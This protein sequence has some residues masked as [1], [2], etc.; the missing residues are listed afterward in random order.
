[1]KH[2]ALQRM[3][4]VRKRRVESPLL[5]ASVFDNGLSDRKFAFKMVNGNNQATSCTNL[6]GE[7]MSSNLGVYAVKTRNFCRD[8]PAI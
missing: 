2:S 5:F 3:R 8:S 1:M 4:D 6:H 7:L